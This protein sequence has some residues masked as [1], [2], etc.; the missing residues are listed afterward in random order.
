[1]GYNVLLFM[2]SKFIK[3]IK[4]TKL[5]YI[6][7]ATTVLLI[8]TMGYLY[9]NDSRDYSLFK[10]SDSPKLRAHLVDEFTGAYGAEIKPSGNILE[11]DMVAKQSEVEIFNGV[12]TKVWSYNGQVPGPE[13]RLKLG[14]TLKLNFTNNLPQETTIHFHGVR[15]PNAMDGVPGVT[16][17][18]IQPGETFVY[19]FTPK[20]AGTYWY[21]P[22]VRSSE[23]VER[24]LFGTLVVEDAEPWP[25]TQDRVLVIDD[26]RMTNDKQVYPQ[27]NT[28]MDL[29]HDGRW[30]NVITV[31]GK[32]MPNITARPGERIRFRLVNS[33]NARVYMPTIDGVSAKIIAVDGM[34]AREVTD[35]GNL[36][37]SPGNRIDVDITIPVDMQGQRLELRDQFR[38]VDNLLM[39]ININ[40]TPIY[41]PE[42]NYPLNPNVPVWSD[43][44]SVSI[45]KEY[46]L[47]ARRKDGG[48]MMGG[49]EWTINDKAFPDYDPYTFRYGELNT[50][51]FTNESGRLHPMHL[52]G[53]FFKV[54]ARNGKSVY[55]PYFRDTVLVYPKESIDIALVPLDKGRWVSHCHILEHA[56]AGMMTVVEVE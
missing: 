39:T 43:A 6:V 23:Q 49:I 15:V 50:M 27:F 18:P 54:V 34:Y 24:G 53:Q 33:S 47:N 28:P 40:G 44:E 35:L 32:L 3:M 51:R 48:G 55:E 38:D 56:E 46:R 12:K 41:T 9:I 2:I 37:L 5:P 10:E 52:H 21:H 8:A 4:K 26:W 11:M 36:E 25:Y 29:M 45:D 20:D 13:I 42:F 22:H 16:Q 31:N 30:G 19:E 7:I 1:M 17:D 14:D